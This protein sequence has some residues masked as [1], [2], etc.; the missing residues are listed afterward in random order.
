MKTVQEYS[1]EGLLRESPKHTLK[2]R[3]TKTSDSKWYRAN[4]FNGL[5]PA[6]NLQQ[7]VTSCIYDHEA[8]QA[9]RTYHLTW[10]QLSLVDGYKIYI[11]S[12][13]SDEFDFVKDIKGYKNTST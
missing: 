13:G 12:Y 3:I 7:E 9:D 4:V 6:L 2:D 8:Y 1:V 11:N 5:C 10:N